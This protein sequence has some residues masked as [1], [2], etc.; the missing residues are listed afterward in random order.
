MSNKD[1]FNG[2]KI[3]TE[4]KVY[5]KKLSDEKLVEF[6]VSGLSFE[7]KIKLLNEKRQKKGYKLCVKCNEMY[8]LETICVHCRSFDLYCKGYSK[9]SD[10]K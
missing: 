10:G 3:V 4:I 9:K 8:T 1:V 2:K 5:T 6:S 7:D